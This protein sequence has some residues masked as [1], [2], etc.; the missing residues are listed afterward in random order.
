MT[1]V[2]RIGMDSTPVDVSSPF[3]RAADTSSFDGNKI[4]EN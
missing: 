3:W 2:N 4:T 1:A